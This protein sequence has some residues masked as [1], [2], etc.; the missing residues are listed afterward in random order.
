M[1][2]RRSTSRIGELLGKGSLAGISAISASSAK[3]VDS[4]NT[5]EFKDMHIHKYKH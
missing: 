4:E 5:I 3:D 2:D 1:S